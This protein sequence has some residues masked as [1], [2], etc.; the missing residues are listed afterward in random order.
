VINAAVPLVRLIDRHHPGD[1][2]RD[3]SIDRDEDDG[4][5][6]GAAATGRGG[7]PAGLSG[8]HAGK[9]LDSAWTFSR[10]SQFKTS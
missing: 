2:Q 4:R 6:P 7:E 8:S 3:T 10:Q 9:T 1:D 5:R